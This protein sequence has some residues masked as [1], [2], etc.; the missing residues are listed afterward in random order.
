MTTGSLPQSS[1]FPHLPSK[2]III[3]ETEALLWVPYTDNG[4]LLACV[5]EKVQPAY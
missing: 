3:E 5:I 2:P 4:K 1:Y